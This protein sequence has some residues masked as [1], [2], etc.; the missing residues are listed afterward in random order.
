MKY[1]LLPA[2]QVGPYQVQAAIA[3]VYDEAK[4]MDDTGWP[5]ILGLYDLLEELAPGPDG[6]SQPGRGPGDGGRPGG[7][8]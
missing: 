6:R 2:G 5:Q 3:A 8:P 4:S 1:L 7:R